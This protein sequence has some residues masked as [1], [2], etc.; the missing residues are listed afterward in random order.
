MRV[1]LW[2][3]HGSWTD[4]F[5]RGRH[6][7]LVVDDEPQRWPDGV[8]QVRREQLGISRPDVVVFQRPDEPEWFARAFGAET[9]GVGKIYLEHN[10]PDGPAATSGHPMA[11]RDDLLLVHVT[12]FNHLMW[13]SGATPTAVSRPCTWACPL[14]LSLRLRQRQPFRRAPASFPT[15]PAT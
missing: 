7:Y 8:E 5:V 9:E 6:H 10:T 14:S 13:D 4:A 3:L 1:L 15:I 2:H 12:W 11:D